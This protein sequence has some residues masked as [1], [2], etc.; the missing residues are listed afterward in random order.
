MS[1]IRWVAFVVWLYLVIYLWEIS[2]HIGAAKFPF[3]MG[4][5]CGY[6]MTFVFFI[7]LCW[8]R[9][10]PSPLSYGEVQKAW[11]MSNDTMDAVLQQAE[12]NRVWA[13]TFAQ[14]LSKRHLIQ[15]PRKTRAF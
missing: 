6:M 9:I 13:K 5:A 11:R 4:L 15:E 7:I 8:E 3:V 12:P 10:F 1:I 14:N 2:L